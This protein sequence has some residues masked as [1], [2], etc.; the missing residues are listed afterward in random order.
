[1]KSANATLIVLFCC[2]IHSN[3]H[4]WSAWRRSPCGSDIVA[5]MCMGAAFTFIGRAAL[6]AV[7]AYGEA[8]VDR[9]I[10][11]LEQEMLLTLATMGCPD[12]RD[13]DRSYL[14]GLGEAA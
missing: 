8:G 3:R 10:E 6:Y 13:L 9:A 14:R 12:V 7:A 1:M 11:I 5:T 2:P 4:W